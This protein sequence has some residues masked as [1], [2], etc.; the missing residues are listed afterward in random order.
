[1]EEWEALKAKAEAGCSKH[2]DEP[3]DCGARGGNS[4]EDVDADETGSPKS[5][6]SKSEED[7]QPRSKD[8]RSRDRGKRRGRS[9]KRGKRRQGRS[10]RGDS[11]Q[12]NE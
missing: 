1:M 3:C 12:K 11:D 8:S 5:D 6:V 7:T 2:G 9:K 10:R 4:E